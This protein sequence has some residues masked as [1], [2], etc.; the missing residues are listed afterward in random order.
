MDQENF[1]GPD[2]VRRRGRG[3]D[4]DRLTIVVAMAND[5]PDCLI[6]GAPRLLLVPHVT[7]KK[8]GEK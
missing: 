2:N 6:D 3:K 7:W 8:R 1:G 4:G 5:T